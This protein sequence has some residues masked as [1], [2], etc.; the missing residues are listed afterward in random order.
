MPSGC[1]ARA[2][3]LGPTAAGVSRLIAGCLARRREAGGDG[4]PPVGLFADVG[5]A[6]SQLATSTMPPASPASRRMVER[7]ISSRSRSGLWTTGAG[8]LLLSVVDDV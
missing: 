3:R 7:F 5:S 8:W 6:V 4:R 2:R 1:V